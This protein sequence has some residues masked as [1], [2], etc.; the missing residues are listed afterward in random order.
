[1]RNVNPLF[2]IKRCNVDTSL[3]IPILIS[4]FHVSVGILLIKTSNNLLEAA[5]FILL[6]L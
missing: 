4:L 1:M 2:V 5:T 6:T 3:E